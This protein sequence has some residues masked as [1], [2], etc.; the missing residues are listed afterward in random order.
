MNKLELMKT[1]NEVRK[2]IMTAVQNPVIRA[3][4]YLQ[5]IFL[6]ICILRK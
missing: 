5:Q 4:L 2:G 3:D 1:A 6:L